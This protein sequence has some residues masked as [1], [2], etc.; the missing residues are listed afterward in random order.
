MSTENDISNIKT[1][2]NDLVALLDELANKKPEPVNITNNSI[3]GN[4]IIGGTITKFASTGI[5]DDSTRLVVLVNNDGL[6]TDFIDVETLVGSVK[7]E[8]NLSVGGELTV[9][10][11]RAREVIADN[12][13]ERTSSVEFLPTDN[14]IYGQGLVWKKEGP[15][16]KLVY[17]PNPDRLWTSESIDIQEDRAY[18]IAKLPVLSL[19]ALGSTVTKSNLTQVGT[20]H[21]LS[22]DGDITVDQFLFWN[23]NAQRLGIG[24]EAPNG[25][26]SVTSLDAEFVIDPEGD[27]VKIGTWTTDDLTIVTDDTPRI[28]VTASGQVVFGVKGSLDA[29]VNING[30]LGIG[31]NNVDN[32]LSISTAGP[33]KFEGKKFEVGSAI[34]RE[35]VHKKGDIVWNDDPKPTSYVGWVCIREGSPGVWK[36]F[37]Q[38]GS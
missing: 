24:T 3:S 10:T 29:R 14:G 37:G 23:S 5:K 9:D 32:D 2:L 38:I 30:R 8:D 11:I 25:M 13:E 18:H 21:G 16:A 27:S 19:N 34:P 20:L 12:T 1:G 35:G 31:I 28:T 6:L 36:P 26:F 17:L 15:Q 33:V 22:V 7:I 4:A